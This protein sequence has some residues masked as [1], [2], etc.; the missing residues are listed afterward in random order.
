MIEKVTKA[1]L[2]AKIK[3]MLKDL[4][5]NTVRNACTRFQSLLEAVVEAEGSIFEKAIISQS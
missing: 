2:D 4:P 5:R 1:E 3:E